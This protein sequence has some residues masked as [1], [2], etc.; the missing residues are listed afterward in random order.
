MHSALS[1][2]CL[3]PSLSLHNPLLSPSAYLHPHLFLFHYEIITIIYLGCW[4]NL[5][6]ISQYTWPILLGIPSHLLQVPSSGPISYDLAVALIAAVLPRAAEL[7]QRAWTLSLALEESFGC[8][9]LHIF[10]L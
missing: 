5:I 10:L 8:L 3:L 2:A 7:H 4:Q 6:P 9:A 1:F